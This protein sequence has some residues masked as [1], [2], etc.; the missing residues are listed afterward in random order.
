M[1]G[2]PKQQETPGLGPLSAWDVLIWKLDALD[3][4]FDTMAQETDKRLDAMT[5][6]IDKR[7]DAMMQGIDRRLDTIDQGIN[8]RLDHVETRM[9]RLDEEVRGARQSF[10]ILQF[11]AVL[12]FTAMLVSI[13]LFR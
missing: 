1:A 13:W 9:D 7:L 11:T 2:E 10:T 8:R 5:Q 4:R 6:G 3:K 12:G